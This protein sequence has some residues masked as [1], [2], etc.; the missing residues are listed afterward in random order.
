MGFIN[1]QEGGLFVVGDAVYELEEDA[2]F[3]HFGFFTE[4]GNDESEKGVGIERC[5]MKV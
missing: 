4:L 2:V 5:E 3:A 1:D